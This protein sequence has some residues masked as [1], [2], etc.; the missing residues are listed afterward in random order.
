MGVGGVVH[1]I[2]RGVI[3][4]GGHAIGRAAG[5]KHKPSRRLF[6]DPLA[7]LLLPRDSLELGSRLDALIAWELAPVDRATPNAFCGELP[8]F[9][10]RMSR[11]HADRNGLLAIA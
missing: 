11:K 1:R 2:D 5:S 9:M 8:G 4:E 7:K 3:H 10:C 6:P